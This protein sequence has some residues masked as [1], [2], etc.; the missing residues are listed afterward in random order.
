MTTP[1]PA[2]IC[3]DV[4]NTSTSFGIY[5]RRRFVK[6]GTTATN[7]IP[8]KLLKI[9]KIDDVSPDSTVIVS[10]VVPSV[11][12]KIKRTLRQN[13]RLRLLIIG[14]NCKVHIEHK[15]NNVNRLGKDRIVN[16][17]GVKKI[18]GFPA[19]VLDFGTG[20]TCD[21]ISDKGIFEGGL[22]IPGPEISF[23]ALSKKAALL[24]QIPFP[25][26]K[27]KQLPLLGRNTRSCMESGILYGFGAMADGLID[28]FKSRYGNKLKVIATGGLSKTIAPYITSL[29]VLD[30]LLTLRSLVEI[31]KDHNSS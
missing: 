23:R 19:L 22:I 16:A 17:F 1:G 31:Y 6:T 8:E 24:P 4:G 3:V 27:I 10:Q 20:F 14:E 26:G 12:Q 5:V 11:S 13:V 7:N 25:R 15:Y 2:L 28:R 9:I 30:P 29:D 18:Y 21:L